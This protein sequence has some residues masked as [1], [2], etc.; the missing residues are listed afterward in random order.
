M[1]SAQLFFTMRSF[2]SGSELLCL[3]YFCRQNKKV[4]MFNKKDEGGGQVGGI[5]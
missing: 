5:K 4:N 2:Y 3:L 1:S